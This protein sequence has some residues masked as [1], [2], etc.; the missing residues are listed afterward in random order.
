MAEVK[1]I[2]R[3]DHVAVFVSDLDRTFHFYHDLL[4]LEVLEYERSEQSAALQ[5]GSPTSAPQAP[6]PSGNS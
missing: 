2:T 1:K 3:M 6:V 5:G 4:G